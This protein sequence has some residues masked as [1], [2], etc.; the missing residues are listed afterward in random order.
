MVGECDSHKMSNAVIGI[1]MTYKDNHMH[2]SKETEKIFL[3]K[4]NKYF[5]FN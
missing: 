5:Y 2:E 1:H 4:W 3:L